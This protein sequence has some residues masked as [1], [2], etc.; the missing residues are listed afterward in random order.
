MLVL[1]AF[2]A[3]LPLLAQ[4]VDAQS[5][6]ND[7]NATTGK[8]RL[9]PRPKAPVPFAVAQPDSAKAQTLRF[10][11]ADQMSQSDQLTA[12]NAESS[13]AEHAELNGFDL[14]DG[15]WKYV[16]IECPAFPGHLFLRYT[17]N[18]G[19]TDLTVFSASIPR[20]QEGRVRIVPILKRSYSLFAPA[21]INALT[22]SAFNHIRAEEGENDSSAWVGNGLCYAALA[23][24]NPRL[25]AAPQIQP[26]QAFPAMDAVLYTEPAGGAVIRFVDAAP[27][28]RPMEWSMT[29]NAKG[30]LVKATHAP[31][32]MITPHAV[33]ENSAAIKERPVP[34][35]P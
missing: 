29:F 10:I 28:P 3:G 1:V 26:G 12:S 22:I 6:D 35:S 34:Q 18:N 27:T 25:P 9:V 21:P 24:A 15:D 19:A 32:S 30:K 17:R 31:A 14:T 2:G 8:I 13:I 33:P 5:A 20:G 7:A 11:P 23:G 16:Q 4:S